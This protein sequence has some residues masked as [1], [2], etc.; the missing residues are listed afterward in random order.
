MQ[1]FSLKPR[2]SKVISFSVSVGASVEIFED[3]ITVD[4][5]VREPAD[6]FCQSKEQDGEAV[7]EDSCVE[8]FLNMLDRSGR[9]INLEFN[10]KGVCY[11]AIGK[12]RENRTEV[13]EEEYSTVTRTLGK[14]S[15]EGSFVRWT[16]SV[17]IPREL[18]GANNCNLSAALIEGNI[19]K[20]S[21]LS[22][23]P[24]WLS[25]FPIKTAKPDFHRPEFFDN[26]NNPS[27]NS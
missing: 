18:L 6:C 7:W 24:H 13:S 12:D 27:W 26:L 11:A 2:W 25:A 19:Y 17:Q 1:V 15:T 3:N 4:F 10:S 14:V 5:A 16:L 8:I 21:D 9:Y 20:C 22:K 23:E